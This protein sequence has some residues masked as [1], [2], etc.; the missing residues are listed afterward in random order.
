MPK[1]TTKP[2]RRTVLIEEGLDKS[3]KK[4]HLENTDKWH[5]CKAGSFSYGESPRTPP[6]EGTSLH[7]WNNSVERPWG[8]LSL[9][10]TCLQ[11]WMKSHCHLLPHPQNMPQKAVEKKRRVLQ[12]AEKEKLVLGFLRSVNHTGSPQDES[13]IHTLT[14]YLGKTTSHLNTSCCC[15][16]TIAHNSRHNTINSRHNQHR[17]LHFTDLQLR[18][19]QTGTFSFVDHFSTKLKWSNLKCIYIYV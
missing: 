2:L 17:Y 9:F 4:Q 1:R 11:L 13:Y 6:L 15:C 16:F 19:V 3:S 7:R 14:L 10:T 18:K 5:L 8:I 12:N